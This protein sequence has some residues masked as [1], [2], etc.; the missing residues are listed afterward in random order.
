MKCPPFYFPMKN[1]I[2]NIYIHHYFSC[3]DFY[4]SME[5]QAQ[6]L[7]NLFVLHCYLRIDFQ[8]WVLSIQDF[9]NS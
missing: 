4:L 2:S 3:L 8:I 1:Y 5:Y 6:H 9:F 7:V